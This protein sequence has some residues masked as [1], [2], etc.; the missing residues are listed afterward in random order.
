MTGKMKG[1]NREQH[2]GRDGCSAALVDGEQRRK[3]TTIVDAARR[4]DDTGYQRRPRKR[5]V[6]AAQGRGQREEGSIGHITAT[7]SSSW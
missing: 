6:P 5:Y 7:T 3:A 2:T 1:R 4:N